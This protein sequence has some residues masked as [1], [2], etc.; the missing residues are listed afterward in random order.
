MKLAVTALPKRIHIQVALRGGR[1]GGSH[2]TF[3]MPLKV[4]FFF[5]VVLH[6][7]G[8]VPPWLKGS[9]YRVGPGIIQVWHN[10]LTRL[11]HHL[12]SGTSTM[13]DQNRCLSRGPFSNDVYTE[14][15]EE[16]L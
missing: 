14:G 9:F 3:S 12:F 10:T 15:E 6:V 8:S 16:G 11:A 5:H 4:A 2:S 13:D 7:P 1:E